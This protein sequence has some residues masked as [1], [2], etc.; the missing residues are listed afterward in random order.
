MA[1]ISFALYELPSMKPY[2]LMTI[3]RDIKTRVVCLLNDDHH[4]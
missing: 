1:N 3:S 2:Y 4:K